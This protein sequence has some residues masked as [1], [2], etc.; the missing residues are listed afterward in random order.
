M[1]IRRLEQIVYDSGMAKAGFAVLL[2]NDPSY[3]ESPQQGWEDRTDGAFRVHEGRVIK[4]EM[5][6][7]ERTFEGT[8]KGKEDPIK[9][10]GS[11]DVNW[12][13]YSILKEDKYGKFRYLVVEVPGL[14]T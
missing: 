12:R 6:W 13:N 2:T 4:G 1:D 7:S 8:K 3:W 11:Y 9:L 5:K 14:K 10:K